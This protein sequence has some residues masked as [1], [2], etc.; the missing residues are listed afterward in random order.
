MKWRRYAGALMGEHIG[1]SFRAQVF[2]IMLCGMLVVAVAFV[3]MSRDR[4]IDGLLL[5]GAAMLML[6]WYWR[7]TARKRALL[8]HGFHT[9]RR[10]GSHWA[11]EEL[12]AGTVMA[13][14]LPLDYVGRGE[15]EVHIPSERDWQANMPDWA[16]GRRA[17]IVARL[18]SVFKR[19]QIHFD[20]DA[21]AAPPA[22]G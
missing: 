14:E 3:L 7:G 12:H 1:A 16:R 18:E 21:A 20:P 15:Y 5:A 8:R 6:R 17:E 13:I 19:S 22:D 9:G 11:Y 2:A 10:L 4:L